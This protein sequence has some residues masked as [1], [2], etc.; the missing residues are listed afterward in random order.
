MELPAEGYAGR[1]DA[2]NPIDAKLRVISGTGGSGH[3]RNVGS[4]DR[5]A[6]VLR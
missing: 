4:P 1:E 6:R 5:T 3:C 2:P